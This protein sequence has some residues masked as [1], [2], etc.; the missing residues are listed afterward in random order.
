MTRSTKCAL[1][2]ETQKYINEMPN[3]YKKTCLNYTLIF[4]VFQF[5]GIFFS[6]FPKKAIQELRIRVL[7]NFNPL[8]GL[9]FDGGE[10]V[11]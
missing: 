1:T 11:D 5:A 7:G 2:A 3:F 10:K 8:T 4:G 9:G 6:K